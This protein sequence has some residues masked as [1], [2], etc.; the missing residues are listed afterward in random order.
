[1]I[2]VSNITDA[3]KQER[4]ILHVTGISATTNYVQLTSGTIIA[5]YYGDATGA[6]DIDISDLIHMS[7]I[8]L[9]TGV[10][11]REYD[12]A[13]TAQGNSVAR[14]ITLRGFINP[15][16]MIIPYHKAMAWMQ[17]NGFSMPIICP[18]TTCIESGD[19]GQQ[20]F[21]TCP[22][23]SGYTLNSGNASQTLARSTSIAVSKDIVMKESRDIFGEEVD[24]QEHDTEC[25]IQGDN[26]IVLNS[27][28][29]YLSIEL[30]DYDETI[31][32]VNGHYSLEFEDDGYN[33]SL[34]VVFYHGSSRGGE[35][36]IDN[37]D[38][39]YFDSIHKKIVVDF[40]VTVTTEDPSIHTDNY[41]ISNFKVY[42]K[43]A[44][45]DCIVSRA[46]KQ[47]CNNRYAKVRWTSRS[48]V[49]KQNV[50]EVRDV[51]DNTAS[52]TNLLSI[53]N[54]YDVRKGQAQTLKLCIDN[55]TAY[56]YWYYS[57]MLTSSSVEVSMDGTN[58]VKV[59]VTD[60]G[61]TIPN[62]NAGEFYS[63]VANVNYR[64]YDEV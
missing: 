30:G 18:P 38:L 16:N 55:L 20:S 25:I 11:L 2:T 36:R 52:K 24:V 51:T 22:I 56:D 53:K 45:G 29:N 8:G 34:Y 59:E 35:I 4:T 10:L 37:E 5:K 57:D 21:E 40:D 7:A 17:E 62:G 26:F 27:Q 14:T 39:D 32:L 64:R 47:I 13:G 63:F 46:Q 48:G 28:Y 6:L 60:K 1:M 23:L 41:Y 9:S 15:A 61:A 49:Q 50:F 3:W 42:Q 33:D 54:E 43:N 58:W 12:A 31:Q 19:F 44:G